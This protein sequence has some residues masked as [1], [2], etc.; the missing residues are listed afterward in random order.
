MSVVDGPHN[1]SEVVSC[2]SMIDHESGRFSVNT[3]YSLVDGTKLL[4]RDRF[5]TGWRD[6]PD[7]ERT[8]GHVSQSGL[9]RCILCSCW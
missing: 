3:G 4:V 5:L 2:R 7:P 6:T 1:S 8:T 9:P